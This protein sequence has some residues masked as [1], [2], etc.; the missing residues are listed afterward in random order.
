MSHKYTKKLDDAI[1]QA[2]QQTNGDEYAALRLM[3]KQGWAGYF[4]G[5]Q[6][7]AQ[8]PKRKRRRSADKKVAVKKTGKVI[9]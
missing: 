4:S 8:P 2:L 1:E 3:L 5:Q 6:N 7:S 9:E